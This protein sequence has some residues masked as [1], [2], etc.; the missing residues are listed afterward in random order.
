MEK[1]YNEFKLLSNKQSIQE[2]SIQRAVKMST[3]ILY[4]ELFDSFPIAD[5]VLKDF[6]FATRRRPDSK[7]VKDDVIQW[8]YF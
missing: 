5:K 1:E 4:D 7:K 2:V 8:F 6:L 3:Q